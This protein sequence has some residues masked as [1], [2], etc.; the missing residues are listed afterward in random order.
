MYITVFKTI[1]TDYDCQLYSLK[2][3]IASLYMVKRQLQSVFEQLDLAIGVDL[4]ESRLQMCYY[5]NKMFEVIYTKYRVL[6]NIR[7]DIRLC[8]NKLF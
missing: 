5:N 6:Q 4:Y 2:V 1:L 8:K 7:L 3:F